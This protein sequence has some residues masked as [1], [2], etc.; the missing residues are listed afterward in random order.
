MYRRTFYVTLRSRQESRNFFARGFRQVRKLNVKFDDNVSTP[1]GVF[2]VWQ[3][4]ASDAPNGRWIYR[5]RYSQRCCTP[6]ECRHIY[7]H[8]SEYCLHHDYSHSASRVGSS[9]Y[10]RLYFAIQA[11]EQ[12]HTIIQN[13]YKSKST[14]QKYMHKAQL[15][16]Q[17]RRRL[18]CQVIGVSTKWF[19]VQCFISCILRFVDNI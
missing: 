18:F 10:I 19:H 1:A 5:V 7:R 8:S 16:T 17:P 11:A 4:L 12:H 14:P 13:K 3:T 15:K 2:R 9:Q 6:T